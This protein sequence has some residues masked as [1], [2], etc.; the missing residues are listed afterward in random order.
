MCLKS[1]M[2]KGEVIDLTSK[3]KYNVTFFDDDSIDIVRQKIASVVDSHPDRLFILVGSRLPGDYYAKDPR[4][5]ERLFDRLS[6][7]GDPLNKSVFQEYQTQYRTP[8]TSIPF[9][10]Y[11]KTAWMSK[12]DALKEIVEGPEFV[13]YRILGVE[14]SK[15]FVLPISS[16]DSTLTSRISSVN[17]PIPDNSSL[18]CSLHSPQSF[19]RF[20]VR[21]YDELAEP[22]MPVY[23]PLLRSAT[24][25][26]LTE[27]SVRL[28]QKNSKLL[29]DLLNLDSP[30]PQEVTVIRTRFYVPFVD[31]DFGSAVR[32]R[33]EQ[34]FYGLTVSE[35][36]P[37]IGYFTSKDQ[38]SRHKF[39]TEDTK[40]KK[41][42]LDMSVWG[43]W[44]SIKPARNTPTLI[45]FRGKSKQEFERIAITAGDMVISHHR[46]EGNTESLE[47]MRDSTLKWI[48]S[49][50]S[51]IPFLAETDIE[52][53]RWELQDLS[54][55]AKYRNK[56]EDFDLLRFNCISSVFDI[57]DKTKS[58]FSLLRTDHSNN[59]LSAVEVKIVQMMKESSGNVRAEDVAEELSI[60]IQN[61]RELIGQ[62]QSRIEED[63]RIVERAFRGFPTLRV[64]PDFIIVSAVSNYTR[65]VKYSN[66]LRYVL[67]S[68]DSKEIDDV[69]PKRMEKV[70]AD[71]T[72]VPTT[73]L[74]VDAAIADEYADLFGYLEQEEEVIEPALSEATD[75]TVA[76][77]STK[78]KQ[79]TTYNY[80]KSRL[81][82]FDPVTFDPA[83]SQYPK[84]CEQ[85]HQPIIL[86]EPDMKRLDGTPYD[87]KTYLEEDRMLDVTEPDGTVV[88]PEYWCM[89]DQIPL[90]EEQLNKDSGEIRCPVC[91]GK[92][93][94][95]SNDDPREYPL[96]KRETGFLYPGYVDYKAPKNGKH[97]PCC[98]KKARK[99]TFEKDTDDKY[100]I[101]S[102]SKTGLKALRIGFI[103]PD[104]NKSLQINETYEILGNSR[105]LQNGMSGFFRTGLEQISETLPACLSL[106]T[107]IP[108][109]REAVETVLKCSF[110]RNWK[111]LGDKHLSSIEND[112]KK[113]EP[114]DK[115]DTAREYVTKIV[116][117]IDEAFEKKQLSKIEELE[118]SALALQCD[119]FRIFADSNTLGCMF[120]SPMNKPRNR[121]II[122]LQD[123]N[124]FD[125][126][127]HVTRLPRGFTYHSN[128]FE[129][130]FKKE[131]YVELEKLR[132]QACSTEIPSYNQALNVIQQ[133]LSTL[134]T[135]DYSIILDPY[136]RGQAFYV[137]S[138]LILPFQSTPLPNVL[139]SKLAGYKEISKEFLPSR[140]DMIKN[141]E[142][143][144]KI[145]SG[146]TFV[147][148][149]YNNHS[150]KVELLTKSG[151][152]IPIKPEKAELKEP[153]EVIETMDEIGE[154][155]LAFGE[156]S[157]ETKEVQRQISYSSEV[158]EFLLFQ[159]TQD[160][161][162]SEYRELRLSLQEVSPKRPE[163]EPLLRKW[164]DETTQFV[165]I[166]EPTDFIS[167]IRTP[168]G[169]FTSKETCS[170]NLCG[171]DG[172]V[173][174]IQIKSSIIQKEKL[175]H[176]L[177]AS[178]IDNVKIRAMVLDGRTTPFFSTILYLE[179][180]HEV[181]MTDSELP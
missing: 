139:Q 60:P 89:R 113:I 75:D 35:E 10:A 136:G 128:I 104:L 125:I 81:Q 58:Q 40:E 155:K 127:S 177:E 70:T 100:Y 178:L 143:A 71:T 78:D 65:S 112:L 146:Y 84:K 135:D 64:G 118:Y 94:T 180:P 61:A 174:R 166:K 27:E 172:K 55:L 2:L 137:K 82:K 76:R 92:L 11:D 123:G 18:F 124:D 59:G 57:S 83:G 48:K 39:Y 62:V 121:G 68:P 107:K 159:L 181:I 133:L 134:D 38:I 108:S 95:R 102:E 45:L 47:D 46:P 164:F 5:W 163:V 19:V 42:L 21:P 4:H 173:C 150:E 33:F 93:Q 105:R 147:E 90:K 32:T 17:L 120:Y 6:Y 158:Y 154:S 15:S 14:E 152:R 69:C 51:I 114:F 50:D 8:Q 29:A 132:N 170:G 91:K 26:R 126:I 86:S 24:P 145:S 131:T 148:D 67:S 141:L 31:T 53:S 1:K 87:V 88:C 37:Y 7:N 171:W 96:I 20:L 175:F 149:L 117:G 16:L 79:T 144:S 30:E 74:E 85:K 129:S 34:I 140:A 168:C 157:K 110:V 23:Y 98:F 138:K 130:P 142:V 77:I 169:Q 160:L 111:T 43:S 72:V 22:V 153:L 156:E 73:T 116:S 179:L 3:T 115:D 12:P 119:V 41:P 80:F 151:L 106:K 161:E 54:Y 44:W 103:P 63:P 28:L 165:D 9:E 13:E 162:M 52:L 49:L 97:M 66:L 176:R 99:K 122:I 25:P 56:L 167:K 101:M 109:P 36:T